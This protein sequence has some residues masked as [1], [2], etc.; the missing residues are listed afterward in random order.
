MC[1]GMRGYYV[2]REMYIFVKIGAVCLAELKKSKLLLI[3]L[4]VCHMPCMPR[5]VYAAYGKWLVSKWLNYR[6]I[7]RER[8]RGPIR[9]VICPRG[10]RA[11]GALF[12]GRGVGA[13]LGS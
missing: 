10:R 5:R 4:H 9:A 7:E 11:A 8:R 2:C 13:A 12:F 6:F 1:D 3:P